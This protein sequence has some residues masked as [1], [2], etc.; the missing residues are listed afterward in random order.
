MKLRAMRRHHEERIK[1]RVS[2]YYGGAFK[3][4]KRRLGIIAG[5]RQLCSC[6]MC[7]NPRKW[8]GEKTVQE[9]RRTDSK[10]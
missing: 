1:R 10:L 8:L 3:H 2:E 7:G 5:S 4:D 6:W 9:R